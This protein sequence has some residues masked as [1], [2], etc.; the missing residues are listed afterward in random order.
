[1]QS[2]SVAVMSDIHGNR[3]A[4]EAVLSDIRRRGIRDI[5]NLG[6]SLYGPLDPAATAAM[7]IELRLPTVAG[8]EDRILLEEPGQ[9]KLSVYPDGPNLSV[10]FRRQHA[11]APSLAFVQANLKSEHRQWIRALPLNAVAFSDFFLFHGTPEKD[12][13]YFLQEVLADGVRRRSEAQLLEMLKTH[14][15]PVLLCGHDH[16]P[17]FVRLGDGRHVINPGSVG[18]PAY[19][20]HDPF[21]HVMETGSPHARYSVISRWSSGV[22]VQ[23]IAVPYDWEAAAL[24]AEKNGRPDWA[25]FLRSGRVPA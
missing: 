11:D 18:L 19:R 15:Q 4:L 1:M 23:N 12:N 24:T 25:C 16:S 13:E 10:P 21:P 3:W 14:M 20:D 22:A 9:H 2:P 6:D 7:L 5:V 8:N 17:A